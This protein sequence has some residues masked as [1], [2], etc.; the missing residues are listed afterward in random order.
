GNAIHAFSDKQT[1]DTGWQLIEPYQ[2]N[3]FLVLI[4]NRVIRLIDWDSNIKWTKAL[5]FHHDVAVDDKGDI[6]SVTQK[7]RIFPEYSTDEPILDNYLVI[8]TK[9]GE[10]KKEISF[11]D[12]I[13]RDEVLFDIARNPPG[14]VSFRQGAWDIFHTN[15]IEI[16]DRDIFYKN[17]NL[18]TRLFRKKK[19]LFKKG[20]VL[21]CI[22][23]LD[24]IGLIDI[25]TERIVWHWGRGELDYPHHPSLLEN[26]NLL[27]FDNGLH[28]G[29]SRVIEL[30]PF[31]EKIEWHY[32]AEPPQLFFSETRGSAQ[33]LPNGNTLITESD[34][35]RVFEITRRG[36]FVWE[37]YSPQ[38]DKKKNK[39]ATIYR[40]MRIVDPQRCARI[41]ELIRQ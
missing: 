26:G 30:N 9:D 19:M 2:D 1:K 29:Y 37:F 15:T 22:R 11:A 28:R 10:L 16:I 38:I 12:M 36:E 5:D 20:D 18:F 3:D 33:R 6:Y 32:T 27:I 8:L 41:M 25:Q 35:G 4:Q 34:K 13:M 39:R 24:I 21:F 40:M 31:T 14:R 7:P 17:K 23:H